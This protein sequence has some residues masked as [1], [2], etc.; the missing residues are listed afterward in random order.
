M[1]VFNAEVRLPF[2]GPQEIAVI[3]SNRFFST[4]NAFFDAGV[5]WRKDDP[6]IF[7]FSFSS[8]QRIPVFSVG[9]AYRINLYG[10]LAAEIYAAKPLQRP[11]K[12]LLMGIAITQ[13]W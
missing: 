9:L 7:K 11:S 12:N 10:S 1:A 2:T 8:T 3:K 13:G 6:P 5:A 4:M